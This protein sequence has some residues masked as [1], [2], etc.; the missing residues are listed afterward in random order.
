MF[1][2]TNNF[3][4]VLVRR[5]CRCYNMLIHFICVFLTI[6]IYVYVYYIYVCI[7]RR[8]LCKQETQPRRIHLLEKY[9]H[10]SLWSGLS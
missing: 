5:V 6:Y 9:V 4:K 8:C 7:L 1:I 2:E 10:R 3:Y